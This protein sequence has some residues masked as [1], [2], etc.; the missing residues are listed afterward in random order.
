PSPMNVDF[1]LHEGIALVLVDRLPVNAIDAGVRAGLLAAIQQVQRN[2]EIL[3]V[4]IACRGRT[5]M[6]GA[7]LAE[8]GGVIP[9]PS[10]AETLATIEDCSKPVIA[11]LHGTALG[12]GL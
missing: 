5:F 10:Y 8:L 4:V 11:S 3:A 6:S 9:A 7:D 2:P 1:E 12:G